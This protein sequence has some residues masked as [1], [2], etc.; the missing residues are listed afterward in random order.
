MKIEDTAATRT[1][2]EDRNCEQSI[3]DILPAAVY[4]CDAN[5]I[6]TY[7]N[8]AAA[9]L[10]G[11][12]PEI[13]KDYWCGSWKVYYRNGNPM[14][15][16]SCPMAVTLKEQRPVLGED[17]IIERPDGVKLNV[18]PHPQPLF[19]EAGEMTGAL[20]LLIKCTMKAC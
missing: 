17:I 13:G 5:G 8:D 9:E 10:W 19:N 15:L 16:E 14:P 6:I 3:A 4:I 1:Q 2:E 12:R 20:T 7:Y 18:L 11:R